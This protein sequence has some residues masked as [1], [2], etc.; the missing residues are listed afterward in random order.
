MLGLMMKS[1][2]RN[3]CT[4]LTVTF[5]ICLHG[6][7]RGSCVYDRRLVNLIEVQIPKQYRRGCEW[8]ESPKTGFSY[9]LRLGGPANLRLHVKINVAL[10]RKLDVGQFLESL[11]FGRRLFSSLMVSSINYLHI[12]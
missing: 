1:C 4:S 12:S 6:S 7:V 2:T 5:S 11:L 8:H 3:G 10:N 9:C